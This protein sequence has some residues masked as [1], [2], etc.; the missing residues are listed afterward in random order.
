MEEILALVEPLLV[1]YS[2]KLGFILQAVSIS[3]SVGF[4]FKLLFSSAQQ[5]VNFTPSETDNAFLQKIFSN[6]IYKGVAFLL[7]L[8]ARIKLPVK[9]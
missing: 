5:Y 9:K 6:K 8:F 2:G 3:G 1:A 7:D 4:V